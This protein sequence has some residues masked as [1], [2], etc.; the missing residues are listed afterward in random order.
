MAGAGDV[1]E[2]DGGVIVEEAEEAPPVLAP[3]PE[4][5]SPPPTV[6]EVISRST[7]EVT[8]TPLT[9]VLQN[10]VAVI[11][12]AMADQGLDEAAL[13]DADIKVPGR[14]AVDLLLALRG[15]GV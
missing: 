5:G 8:A 9:T 2:V 13:V 3:S 14:L 4:A 7:A 6:R 12:E 10:L 11:N 1:D 15:R